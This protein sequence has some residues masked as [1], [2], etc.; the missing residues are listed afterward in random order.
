MAV[1]V[2]VALTGRMSDCD[3]YRVLTMPIKSLMKLLIG[4]FVVSDYYSIYVLLNV[5][6]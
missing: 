6:C 5:Y 3:I 2:I 1:C 4:S